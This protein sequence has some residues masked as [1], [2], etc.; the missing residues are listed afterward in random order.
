MVSDD[1]HMH[2]HTWLVGYPVVVDGCGCSPVERHHSSDCHCIYLACERECQ[3]GTSGEDAAPR[4]LATI[5]PQCTILVASLLPHY[6]SWRRGISRTWCDN[7]GRQNEGGN[8]H[9][10]QSTAHYKVFWDV[11]SGWLVRGGYK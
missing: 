8:A 9:T 2:R 3:G 10:T 11:L 1:S 7:H 5:A 4:N 6:W